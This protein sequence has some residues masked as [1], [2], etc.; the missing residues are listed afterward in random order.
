[1]IESTS[2]RFKDWVRILFSRLDVPWCQDWGE[3]LDWG[4]SGGPGHL[5]LEHWTPLAGPQ[6]LL[7]VLDL[8]STVECQ[9]GL[10]WCTGRQGDAQDVREEAGVNYWTC[11]SYRVEFNVSS[12][13]FPQVWSH[14][15]SLDQLFT[16][17]FDNVQFTVT[18]VTVL[19]NTDKRWVSID[20]CCNNTHT[21]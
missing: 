5:I 21:W 16:E 18:W 7:G 15:F 14:R 13:G 6:S 17:W 10:R 4:R 19:T 2:S 11:Y 12:G 1:M 20:Q 9:G 8:C 3:S